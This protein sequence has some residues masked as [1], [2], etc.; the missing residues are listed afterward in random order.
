MS[1]CRNNGDDSDVYVIPTERG[2]VC[3][4]HNEPFEC[5]HDPAAMIAHLEQHRADGYKV[6]EYAFER[7]RAEV[8]GPGLHGDSE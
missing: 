3:Y 4:T 5:G 2:L 6:P 7:L 8:T 1:Y